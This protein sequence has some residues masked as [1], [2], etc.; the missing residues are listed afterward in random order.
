MSYLLYT[1]HVVPEYYTAYNQYKLTL[2]SPLQY[3]LLVCCHLPF[4]H[5]HFTFSSNNYSLITHPLERR[6]SIVWVMSVCVCVCVCVCLSVR[7]DIS[8][9]TRAILTNFL[10]MLPMSVIFGPPSARWR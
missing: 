5:Q 10:C 2:L 8:R 3:L 4:D 6:R 7:Q 1:I 9:T